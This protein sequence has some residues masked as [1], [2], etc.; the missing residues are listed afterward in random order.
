MLTG[1]EV[2]ALNNTIGRMDRE[3][4]AYQLAHFP[5]RFPIDFTPDFLERE[6]LHRLQHIL[7]GLCLHN[8]KR[9]NVALAA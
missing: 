8:H 2:E 3:T 7:F 1:D 5:A 4:V 9:L 6:P